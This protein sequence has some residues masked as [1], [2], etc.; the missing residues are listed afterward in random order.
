M[1]DLLRDSAREFQ[2]LVDGKEVI[3]S[4]GEMKCEK[5]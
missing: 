5:M 1:A 2:Q 4:E 3:G